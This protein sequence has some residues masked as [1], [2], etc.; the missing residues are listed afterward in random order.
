MASPAGA[1]RF[2]EREPPY[3]LQYVGV[4]FDQNTILKQTEK[5]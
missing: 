2:G 5:K 1:G 4:A 3:W